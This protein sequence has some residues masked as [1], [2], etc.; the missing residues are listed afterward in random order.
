[1]FFSKTPRIPWTTHINP[2]GSEG[3]RIE[4]GAEVGSNVTIRKTARVFEGAKIP[5]NAVLEFGVFYTSEGPL[6]FK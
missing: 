1:M 4:Q 6:E 5:D 2:D 3:G